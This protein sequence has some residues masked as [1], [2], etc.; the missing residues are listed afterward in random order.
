[1]DTFEMYPGRKLRIITAVSMTILPRQDHP[2]VHSR[3]PRHF[4]LFIRGCCSWMAD[5]VPSDYRIRH[6]HHR[7]KPDTTIIRLSF[8][9]TRFTWREGDMTPLYIH[10]PRGI[11]SGVELH[12]VAE[13]H[14]VPQ[15]ICVTKYIPVRSAR[16]TSIL[17]RPET[18]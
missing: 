14:H 2:L 13:A 4:Y 11:L 12:P 3:D 16:A 18:C 9:S 8:N 15:R 6:H 10:R 17:R 1:M 7:V 5:A